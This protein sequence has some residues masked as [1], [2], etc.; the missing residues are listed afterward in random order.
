MKQVAI[1]VLGKD[2]PGIVANVTKVLYETGCNIA[3]SSMTQLKSEFAMILIAELPKNI[4]TNTLINKLKSQINK[5]H[6][7]LSVRELKAS[8]IKKEKTVGQVYIISVFGSD[9]PGIVYG[10]SNILAKNRINIT[11]VQTKITTGTYIM[12]LEIKIPTKIDINTLKNQMEQ[13]SLKL[14]V[15]VS[16]NP[17]DTPEL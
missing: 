13:L 1:S 15:S 17:V 6:L 5:L 3:D 14:N 2:R 10:I 12:L 11:D 9:K 16:I 4:S 8:E 7:S